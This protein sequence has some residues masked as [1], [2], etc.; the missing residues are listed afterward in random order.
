L[1]IYERSVHFECKEASIRLRERSNDEDM[2]A[3]FLRIWCRTEEEYN[4]H[5][6]LGA[7]LRTNI[8]AFYGHSCSAVEQDP[9]EVIEDDGLEL[10]REHSLWGY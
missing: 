8:A 6:E 10:Y 7:A 4:V 9:L 3:P 1:V 5:F 2:T